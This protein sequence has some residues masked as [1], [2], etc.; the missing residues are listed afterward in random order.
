MLIATADGLIIS[1]IDGRKWHKALAG[2]PVTSVIAREGVILAG[3]ENGVWR[4]DDLGRTWMES[5]TGL[6]DRAIRWLSFHPEVSDLELAG[7]PT[8]VFVSR[9]GAQTW[10]PLA[11]EPALVWQSPLAA[12]GQVNHVTTML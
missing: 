12:A 5:S 3:T 6:T 8:S 2:T 10:R 4:S 7:T 9:D 11:D 1:Q